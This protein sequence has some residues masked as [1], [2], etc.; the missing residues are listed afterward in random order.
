MEP[1]ILE[2]IQKRMAT[3]YNE[4]LWAVALVASMSGFVIT[5]VDRL[6]ASIDY[7]IIR[8][9][10]WIVTSLCVLFILLRHGVYLY[11]NNIIDQECSIIKELS[12]RM[13]FLRS[14]VSFSG[15]LLYTS[16]TVGMAIAAILTCKKAVKLK[17]EAEK[18]IAQQVAG[19]DRGLLS[20]S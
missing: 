13:T 14:V 17:K 8:R 12:P 2:L 15:V 9:G 1:E 19:E 10:I 16:V 7:K 20:G 5:Q 4:Q 3:S 18:C 6:V 11:Y